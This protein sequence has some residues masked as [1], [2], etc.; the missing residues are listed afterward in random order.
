MSARMTATHRGTRQSDRRRALRPASRVLAA[1]AFSLFGFVLAGGDLPVVEPGV[2]TFAFLWIVGVAMHKVSEFR[3]RAGSPPRYPW[4][5]W[6]TLVLALLGLATVALLG[7][8]VA[9]N[10]DPTAGTAALGAIVLAKCALV[11]M[12][13]RQAAVATTGGQ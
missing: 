5:A 13:A 1:V 8:V 9:A 3:D 12:S 10:L 4:P 11:A 2:G 6:V 7:M